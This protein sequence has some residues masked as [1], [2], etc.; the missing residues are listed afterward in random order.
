VPFIRAV[1]MLPPRLQEVEQGGPSLALG[2]FVDRV[3]PM[4][5]YS[6]LFLVANVKDPSILAVSTVYAASLLRRELGVEASPTIAVRDFNKK[7]LLTEVFTSL[8]A[9]LTS[10]TL[11]WGDDY[12][13]DAGISNVREFSS[14]EQA[15]AEAVRVGR[16]AGAEP[17]V[18]API[19]VSKLG[20]ER[21]RRVAFGRIKAGASLLLAQPPTVGRR[22][23][24]EHLAAL[25]DS[26][27]EGRVLL[28]VFPFTDIEDATRIQKLFGWDLQEAVGIL[29]DGGSEALIRESREVVGMMRQAGLP[30]VYLSTRASPS[31]A[32]SILG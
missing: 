11:V 23:F 18:I 13:P 27:L 17:K 5:P 1:E 9:G 12:D 4:A 26:G 28:N 8:S 32:K 22:G 21:E 30:G 15:I 3:R 7:G 31:H 29:R 10:M 6:D 16:E 20:G 14:L 25:K 19:D 24:R 2:G